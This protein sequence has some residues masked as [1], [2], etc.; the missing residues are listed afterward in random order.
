MTETT[1]TASGGGRLRATL[2][3]GIAV[4]LWATLALLTTAAQPVPPF[5]LMA[6]TFGIAFLLALGKWSLA[7]MNGGPPVI[8]HLRQPLPVW[9]LGV[10]GLFGYHFFYFTALGQAPPADAS[11]IAFLWPLLLVL[12]SAL[13]PGER[14]RW[15]H[16]AGGIAGLFGAALLVTQGGGLTLRAEYAAGYLAALACAL[17]WSIYSVVNRRFGDVPS[18]AVGGFCGVTAVLG[19]LAHLLFERTAWPDGGGWLAILALG[20]GPVGAAFFVWDYGVKHGDIRA[21]GAFAY[22]APLLSTLL[23]I[24]FGRAEASWTLAAACALIVG[25]AV[26]AGRDMLRRR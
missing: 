14:L 24:A 22:A 2:V 21:L 3:G 9:A 6:L 1:V 10:A 19:L 23:L 25:G 17:T 5:Q 16:L 11:L 26:L 4:L 20:I 13:L 15:W 18:D 8:S 7:R 12:F